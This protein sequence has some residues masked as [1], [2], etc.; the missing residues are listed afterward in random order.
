MATSSSSILITGASSG[1]GAALA[2]AYAAPGITLALFGRNEERLTE[3]AK[4]CEAKGATVQC[5]L[6]DVRD[7]D[8]MQEAIHALDDAKPF[9]LVIANAG[10]SAGTFT[11][12]KNFDA[13]HGVFDVNLQ[14]VLHTMHPIITRMVARKHG[15]I[16]I[17]SSLA[18]IMPW[19]GAAAYSASKAAVRYYGEALRPQLAKRNVW[20]SVVCPGWIHTPLVAVN[21]FPMPF[22]M[23]SE[24]AARIIQQGI[25]AR[26][27]RI[28]FPFSLYFALRVLQ[29][30]P[31]VLSQ[32]LTSLMPAK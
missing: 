32:K 28:S 27:T 25:S 4:Q 15:Q 11:G 24:R 1:L 29:A 7:R 18:G 22:I 2:H 6:V 14:G 5:V 21:K 3:V 17:I 13:A 8:A 30:L 9:N 12:E 23:S 26:K 20:V 31:V 19:P 10:I 16:A